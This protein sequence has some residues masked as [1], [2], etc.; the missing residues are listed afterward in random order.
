MARLGKGK[1]AKGKDA[2]NV[3]AKNANANTANVKNA[4]AKN[5][6]RSLA[7]TSTIIFVIFVAALASVLIFAARLGCL[8]FPSQPN[9]FGQPNSSG[10]GDGNHVACT[11]EAKL[12]PDGSAVGRS[13]PNC[14]FS[15]CPSPAPNSCDSKQVDS[16]EQ[17]VGCAVCPPCPACSSISCHTSDFCLSIGFGQNWYDE[18][19]NPD[20]RCPQGYV[21]EGRVCNPQCYYSTP[22][23]LVPSRECSPLK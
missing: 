5:A 4:N 14:E 18:N 7:A 13:G 20:C 8:G 10:P 6:A 11:M 3:N 9:P 22:K 21:Q 17:T 16:C 12:C 15:P 2:K 19:A 23:C 1:D